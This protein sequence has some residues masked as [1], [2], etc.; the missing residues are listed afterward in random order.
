MRSR[1]CLVVPEI[2]SRHRD[3]ARDGAYAAKKLVG[4]FAILR[5]QLLNPRE[6][7][8]GHAGD[9]GFGLLRVEFI[10]LPWLWWNPGER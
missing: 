2:F 6:H 7:L 3:R 10:A 1:L 9:R 4:P 5:A 8:S